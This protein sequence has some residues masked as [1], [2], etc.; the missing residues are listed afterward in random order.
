MALI[1][2]LLILVLLWH[3]EGAPAKKQRI[4]LGDVTNIVFTTERAAVIPV[5]L[6]AFRAAFDPENLTP[7][8]MFRNQMLVDIAERAQLLRDRAA[9]ARA[10]KRAALMCVYY[11]FYPLN[12]YII[13]F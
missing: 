2:G 9:A 8:T 10:A 1:R 5:L 4:A 3:C 11:N 13:R 7:G 6:P 12:L